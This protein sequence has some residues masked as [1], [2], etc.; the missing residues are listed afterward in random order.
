MDMAEKVQFFTMD[1]ISAVGFGTCFGMLQN[2]SDTDNYIEASD[3]GL[4]YGT[5]ML[6]MGLSWMS[7]APIIGKVFMPTL[8]D[9]KGV[10]K[11]MATCFRYVDERAANPTDKRSD[12]LASFIRHGITGDALRS[13]ALEQVIAGAE[14]TSTAIRGILLNLMANPRVYAKLQR[15]IAEAIASGNAPKAGGGPI[16]IVQA[17]KLPYLQAVIREGLRTWPPVT[18]L[19]PRDV[20]PGG[21]TVQVNGENVFLPGGV[22]IGYSAFAMHRKEEIYGSDAKVFRPERWLEADGEKLAVMIRTNDLVFGHGRFHCLGKT[23]AQIEIG[24]VVF[25]VREMTRVAD[26]SYLLRCVVAP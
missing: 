12:M 15:E 4:V 3:E 6:A 26:S 16:S 9:K 25:E 14:T 10:G 11:M 17:I 8:E 18:T 19:F 21:D 13:E 22:C 23:I 1:V 2:D 7:Q 20:P 24:K 5:Y